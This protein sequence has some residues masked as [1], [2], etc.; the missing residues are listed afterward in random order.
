M[1]QRRGA[2]ALPRRIVVGERKRKKKGA[3][4]ELHD[5][6]AEPRAHLV[7]QAVHATLGTPDLSKSVGVRKEIPDRIGH[8]PALAEIIGVQHDLEQVQLATR[9]AQV[10][11][12]SW[13]LQ[14]FPAAFATIPAAQRTAS[15]KQ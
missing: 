6:A 1:Q 2:C 11:W 14:L 4:D 7:R 15:P 3:C 8:L 10:S 12:F 13:S 9:Q 5:V